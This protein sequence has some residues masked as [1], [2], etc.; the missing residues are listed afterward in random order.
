MSE[1][2]GVDFFTDESLV[3]DPYPYLEFLRESG[4]VVR[5]PH[6]AV[7]SVTSLVSC[8]RYESAVSKKR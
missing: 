3:A 5:A 7:V 4:P 6:H 1:F 2:D 8:S